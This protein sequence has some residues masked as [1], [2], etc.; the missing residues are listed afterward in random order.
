MGH[1][2]RA[3]AFVSACFF[4][5]PQ[6]ATTA[7]ALVFWQLWNWSHRKS[8]LCSPLLA[9]LKL[10]PL[11][12]A[13]PRWHWH[14]AGQRTQGTVHE[15]CIWGCRWQ[16]WRW[17]RIH[18]PSLFLAKPWHQVTAAAGAEQY[19]RRCRGSKPALAR[20]QR[21]KKIQL[22]N[23]SNYNL[24]KPVSTDQTE[25]LASRGGSLEAQRVPTWISPARGEQVRRR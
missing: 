16:W 10:R 13:K 17:G 4:L 25:S 14:F 6:T 18:R 12:N 5:A 9:E 8:C 24:Y 23:N 20:V 19:P 1:I 15:A 21:I 22:K 2:E 11:I 3:F 7:A